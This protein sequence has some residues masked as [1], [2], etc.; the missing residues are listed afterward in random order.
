MRPESEGRAV[1]V[2]FSLFLSIFLSTPLRP[3]TFS[4]FTY[5]VEVDDS[6]AGAPFLLSSFS[7]PPSPAS[8]EGNLKD[9][10]FFFLVGNGMTSKDSLFFLEH[11]CWG[12]GGVFSLSSPPV[13]RAP[14]LREEPLDTTFTLSPRKWQREERFPPPLSPSGGEGG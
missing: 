8:L 11:D 9:I 4:G 10:G 2:S 12:E 14:G 13:T 6:R 7:F 3:K 5:A 1:E